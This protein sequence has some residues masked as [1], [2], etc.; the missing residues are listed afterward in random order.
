MGNIDTLQEFHLQQP[1]LTSYE[2]GGKY[3]KKGVG[4][5]SYH[6]EET[7]S[8]D[9]PDC[10]ASLILALFYRILALPTCHT[11]HLEFGSL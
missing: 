6:G 2:T 7:C 4:C 3:V 9:L 10:G 8:G 5:F 1:Q 11:T